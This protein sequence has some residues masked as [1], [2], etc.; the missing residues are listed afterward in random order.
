[1]NDPMGMFGRFYVAKR[2][3]PELDGA[4][5]PYVVNAQELDNDGLYV[6]KAI[7]D[8]LKSFTEIIK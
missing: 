5:Y 3:M 2:V 7:P 1:M 6:F 4:I 8:R